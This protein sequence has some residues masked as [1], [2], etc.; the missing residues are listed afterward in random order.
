[1]AVAERL[2]K[3]DALQLGGRQVTALLEQIKRHLEAEQEL[4][5][6]DA[7]DWR[8]DTNAGCGC[9]D[10]KTL[11]SYLLDSDAQYLA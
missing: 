1:M 11:K 2:A 3:Q 9:A 10:C 4:A 7:D 5:Y 6:R 8:L